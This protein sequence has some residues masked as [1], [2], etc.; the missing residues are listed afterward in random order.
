MR[1]LVPLVL[2]VAVLGAACSGSSSTTSPSTT[3]T[4]TFSS[5]LQVRGADY[6]TFSV[7]TAGAFTVTLTSLSTST[8]VGLGV[9][10]PNVTGRGCYVTASITTAGGAGAQL[11]ASVD[12]GIYCVTIYD[13]GRLTDRASFSIS[14]V[15]T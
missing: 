9:G 1:I 10:I 13:E 2:L 4:D 6:Q 12:P 7:T 8:T 3:K 14:I 15:H 11:S 5:I